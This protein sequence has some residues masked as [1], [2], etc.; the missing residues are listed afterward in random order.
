MSCL[1]KVYGFTFLQCKLLCQIIWFLQPLFNTFIKILIVILTIT[2]SWCSVYSLVYLISH[3]T[4][5]IS[6]KIKCK[7]D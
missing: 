6:L 2:K 7:T 1:C 4:F 3:V 5:S